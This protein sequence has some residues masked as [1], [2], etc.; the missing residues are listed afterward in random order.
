MQRSNEQERTDIEV[1]VKSLKTNDKTRFKIASTAT[2]QQVWDEAIDERHL[3]EQRTPGDTFRC[4]D[5]TDLTGRLT[6][7]LAQLAAEHVVV[8]VDPEHLGGEQR[9]QRGGDPVVLGGHHGLTNPVGHRQRGELG[10]SVGGQPIRHP[11][12][13]VI[14]DGVSTHSSTNPSAAARRGCA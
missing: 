1:Q 7:K 3:D 5:G 2:L 11:P 9:L 4:E 10:R 12:W 6:T 14:P 8:A 13:E